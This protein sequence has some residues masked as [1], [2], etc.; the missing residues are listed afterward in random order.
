MSEGNPSKSTDNIKSEDH[1]IVENSDVVVA[2]QGQP[3][4]DMPL[5]GAEELAGQ[6]QLADAV[7]DDKNIEISKKD[8]HQF[9][10]AEI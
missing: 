9:I 7:S 2:S 6:E 8:K 1:L 5:T 3:N 4:N 10:S